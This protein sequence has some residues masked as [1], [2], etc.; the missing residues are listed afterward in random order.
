MG[1]AHNRSARAAVH[2]CVSLQVT[3]LPGEE[4]SLQ[5]PRE[6]VERLKTHV[7]GLDTM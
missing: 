6:V 7:F 2:A 1:A 5:V 3:A 4:G